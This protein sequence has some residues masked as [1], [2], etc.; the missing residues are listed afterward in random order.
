V[1]DKL[2]NAG[3]VRVKQQAG[4]PTDVVEF[5]GPDTAFA[6]RLLISFAPGLLRQMDFG[7]RDW[8]R[9]DLAK[10]FEPQSPREF[11][12]IILSL[13]YDHLWDGRG[14]N[15][16]VCWDVI[17]EQRLDEVLRL[18]VEVLDRLALLAERIN[19]LTVEA[20]NSAS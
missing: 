18:V 14:V 20:R 6:G 8:L 1:V 7:F 5:S 10:Q 15:N 4:W 17:T 9:A 16:P 12:P 3:F 13:S 2:A 19:G 11:I